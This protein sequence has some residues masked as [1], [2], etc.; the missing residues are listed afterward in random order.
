[1]HYDLGYV[2]LE[3]KTLQP[4]DNPFGPRLLPMSRAG[5]NRHRGV[6]Y[7]SPP[8]RWRAS[9]GTLHSASYGRAMQGGGESGIRT[10]DGLFTHTRVPGVRLQPLGHLSFTTARNSSGTAEAR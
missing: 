10:H 6:R 4:L 1:M 8:S 5:T 2:D 7:A 3:Q 9:E